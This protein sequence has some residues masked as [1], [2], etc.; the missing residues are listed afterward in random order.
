MKNTFT[1]KATPIS[2]CIA[3]YPNT[4]VIPLTELPLGSLTPTP[5]NN[6]GQVR[7]STAMIGLA[8]SMGATG[9]LL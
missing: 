3:D 6:C 1:P 8:I 7:R 4:S 2:S 5:N 9:L